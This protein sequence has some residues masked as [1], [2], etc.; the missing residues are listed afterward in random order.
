MADQ[1][2]HDTDTSQDDEHDDSTGGTYGVTANEENDVCA[3][4]EKV[5]KVDSVLDDSGEELDDTGDS[6]DAD[7]SDDGDSQDSDNDDSNDSDDELDDTDESDDDEYDISLAKVQAVLNSSLDESQLTPQMRRM[8]HRQE[9]NTRRVEETIK[10]T[11]A[12]PPWLVPTFCALMII[13][14]V[15]AVTFYITNQYPIPGIGNWNLLIA[16]VIIIIGFLMTMLWR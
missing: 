11:K 16:F 3:D 10:G 14:L 9:E 13:G 1:E 2:L 5:V 15:W 6:D 8:V 12:N 4:D 7:G